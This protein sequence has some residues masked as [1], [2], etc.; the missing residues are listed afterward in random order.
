M[1]TDVY[2]ILMRDCM[3]HF[4]SHMTKYYANEPEAHKDSAAQ[5]KNTHY[6]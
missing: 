2:S 4:H 5:R 1:L 3:V 6:P